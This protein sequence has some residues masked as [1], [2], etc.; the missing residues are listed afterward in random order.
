MYVNYVLHV[1]HS[2]LIDTYAQFY[3]SL[4]QLV[5]IT[6]GS[7]RT[8]TKKTW[9]LGE[10][11]TSE[12]IRLDG[13][14]CTKIDV[15][16]WQIPISLGSSKTRGEYFWGMNLVK[17]SLNTCSDK[18]CSNVFNPK[19]FP[20][21]EL[22]YQQTKHSIISNTCNTNISNQIKASLT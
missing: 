16:R 20:W 12:Y 14:R 9:T 8:R 18:V 1:A 11:M 7:Q 21:K 3:I 5:R 19:R 17:A 10:M 2:H 15:C 13:P 22:F 6:A 4:I